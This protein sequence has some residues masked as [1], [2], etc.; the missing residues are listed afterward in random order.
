M[1]G[2]GA[3]PDIK[4]HSCLRRELPARHAGHVDLMFEFHTTAKT[5]YTY[6]D[7]PR[8]QT[9]A[10]KEGFRDENRDGAGLRAALHQA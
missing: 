6:P 5:A 2:L 9:G 3:E 8:H 1:V 7:R 10:G 4:L